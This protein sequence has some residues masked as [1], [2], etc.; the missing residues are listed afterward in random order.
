MVTHFEKVLEINKFIGFAMGAANA[1][2]SIAI[3]KSKYEGLT[4]D[5]VKVSQ[6]MYELC[7]VELG[8]DNGDTINAGMSYAIEL[9]NAHRVI[10]AEKLLT[11]LVVISKR[12]HGSHHNITQN[13]QLLLQRFNAKLNGSDTKTNAPN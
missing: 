2:Q 7:I 12:A 6:D 4:D 5:L 8:E 11:K 10:E 9:K 3:A 13:V 1:M